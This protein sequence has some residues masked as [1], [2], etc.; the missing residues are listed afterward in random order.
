MR[1]HT[2]IRTHA[3]TPHMHTHTTYTCTHACMHTHTHA[4]EK[5][6]EINKKDYTGLKNVS[7]KASFKCRAVMRM[8]EREIKICAA[9][10][11]LLVK[12]L[13]KSNLFKYA[14]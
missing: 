4:A 6:I 11:L 8:K 5:G 7:L 10:N 12:I 3:P 1:T 13:L 9:E 2:H 14:K